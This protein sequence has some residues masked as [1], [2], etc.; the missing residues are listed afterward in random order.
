V[1]KLLETQVDNLMTSTFEWHWLKPA[2][3]TWLPLRDEWG[4]G[5]LVKQILM[6]TDP[7]VILQMQPPRANN[8]LK[9][10]NF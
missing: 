9:L 6:K 2:N 5:S 10:V 4:L 8:A 7:Y 1:A 3:G